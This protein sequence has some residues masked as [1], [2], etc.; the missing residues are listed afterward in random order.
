MRRPEWKRYGRGTAE[1]AEEDSDDPG[2]E[3]TFPPDRQQVENSTPL[4]AGKERF[5]PPQTPLP[6]RVYETRVE[7]RSYELDSFGHVNHAVFFHYFEHARFQALTEAGLDRAEL[8]RR[9]WGLVVVRAE[10]NF[11]QQA[12]Q[13]DELLVTTQATLLR[14]RSITLSH[15]LRRSSDDALLATGGVVTVCLGSDGRAIRVPRDVAA[16]FGVSRPEP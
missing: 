8:A 6:A 13:G 2:E 7:V 14:T 12:I 5:V 3:V 15:E 11:R 16:A 10:A 9:G 1:G 4:D